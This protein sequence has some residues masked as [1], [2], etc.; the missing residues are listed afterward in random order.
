MRHQN[1]LKKIKKTKQRKRHS[2]SPLTQYK[3]TND[4]KIFVSLVKSQ[5]GLIN[6]NSSMLRELTRIECVY[7]FLSTE[8]RN[9][10]LFFA[11]CLLLTKI[12]KQVFKFFFVYFQ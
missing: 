8:F 6:C 5:L 11:V 9:I 3:S 2:K 7:G 12:N 10:F 1:Y 4:I